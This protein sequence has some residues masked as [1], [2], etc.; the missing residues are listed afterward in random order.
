MQ[1]LSPLSHCAQVCGLTSKEM[2][3]GASPR[4]EYE[5]LAARYFRSSTVGKATMRRAM[6]AAIRAAL[7]ASETRSAAELLI[8]LRMMLGAR[9]SRSGSPRRRSRR[10]AY[11]SRRGVEAP[12]RKRPDGRRAESADVVSLAERR[13]ALL[14]GR[15]SA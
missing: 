14:S 10:R 3:V 6:V 15:P 11:E 4:P 1:S 5:L 8:V 12:G 7:K 2:I 9:R 13:A